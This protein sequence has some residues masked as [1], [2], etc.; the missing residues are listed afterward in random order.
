VPADGT[1]PAFSHKCW[2]DDGKR[3]AAQLKWLR[4]T[5]SMMKSRAKT[6]ATAAALAGV[7]V[8]AKV[9]ATTVKTSPAVRLQQTANANATYNQSLRADPEKST[10]RL[11][12]KCDWQNT[13]RH[14]L[15]SA[16]PSAATESELRDAMA[17]AAKKCTARRGS[18]SATDP[19][20]RVPPS[21]PVT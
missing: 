9:P 13:R 15:K 12:T 20:V 11:L 19:T 1:S 21:L 3:T 10:H 8:P 5:N 14:S 17:A 7:P 18:W 4:H 6:I 16:K 2:T